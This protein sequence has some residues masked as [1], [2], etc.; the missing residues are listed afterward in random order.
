VAE[1]SGKDRRGSEGEIMVVSEG[2]SFRGSVESTVLQVLQDN[3]VPIGS[4]CGGQ[5]TC[6]ECRIRFVGRAPDATPND[7][8]LLEPEAIADGWRLACA[9]SVVGT[10][11]IETRAPVG[12]LNQ[13]A[14]GNTQAPEGELDPAVTSRIVEMAGRSRDDQR[15]LAERLKEERAGELRI[16]GNVLRRLASAQREATGSLTVI[17]AGGEVLDVRAGRATSVRGLAIDVGTTTLAVYLFDLVTGRHLG[18]AA[19][20]NPQ[21]R[22]GADVIS[23]VA[24]VRRTKGKG[25]EELHASVIAGLNALI[26]ELVEEASVSLETIYQATA[27]GNPTMLHLLLSIDPRGIDVSPYVS[28]FRHGVRCTPGDIGL[29]MSPRGFVETLPAISAYVGADIVAGILATD[30]ESRRG[31]T[32]FLDVGTNGEIVLALDGRLTAC[33]TAAGPAFEGASIVQGM[34]A[35]DG[36]IESVR[37]VDGR[38]E[39]AV[40]GG[41]KPA[42]LCGTGLVSAVA[43]LYAAGVI[44]P[45]G[46]LGDS[47]SPLADRLEGRRDKRRFRLTDGA[48]IYLHQSDVREFQLAKAAIRAGI[49]ILLRHA[50]LKAEKLASVLIGGAFSARLSGEHLVETGFL[51]HIDPSRIRVVGNTAG[52]GAKRVLLHRGSM[53]DARRLA[54]SVE[55]IELSAD[56]RFTDLYVKQIPF[57][58]NE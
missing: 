23:R 53:D 20:R 52:Q 45:S 49:E 26:E 55:Y 56:P 40:I 39:C 2:V 5:G 38:V 36:A 58:D 44:D 43:E 21:Q 1:G 54:R 13:K 47:D 7:L 3:G 25:L 24:H 15:A 48:A 42:G 31:S 14:A 30:V 10:V 27:V 18:A 35:L 57:P 51:P 8:A 9:H 16:P 46:R 41:T 19:S 6:G 12:N 29:S 37:V 28:V 50:G 22:F 11:R 32:L 34:A 17:E 33:S 4:S